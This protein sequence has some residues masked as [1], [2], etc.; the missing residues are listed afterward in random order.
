MSYADKNGKSKPAPKKGKPTFRFINY[1]LDAAEQEDLRGMDLAVEYPESLLED[2]MV[3]GY[4]FSMTYDQKNTGFICSMIDTSEDSP[5]WNCC[6]S[7]R[8][9]TLQN[10]RASVL[11]RHLTVAQEIWGV[12]DK[13]DPKT[14]SDFG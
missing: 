5:Y 3:A 13:S 6:I 4:K 7:G 1:S 11:Y 12:L 9:S 14:S 8:G 10:A 2:L